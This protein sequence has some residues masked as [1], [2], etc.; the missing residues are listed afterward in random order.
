[1]KKIGNNAIGSR[2]LPLKREVIAVL[3]RMEL[4]DVLGGEGG[5][6]DICRTLSREE[7]VCSNE[8]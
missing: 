4:K 3:T 8:C 7:D 5:T 2:R 1:M 6:G